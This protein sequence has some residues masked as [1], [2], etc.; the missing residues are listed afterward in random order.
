[1]RLGSLL[2]FEQVPEQMA[3][4]TG[5]RVSRE[6]AR[7]L[8]ETAG[9]ALEAVEAAEVDALEAT[10]A[11]PVS[12]P[13]VQ[14]LS[15]DGAM[16][17]LVGGQWSEVKLLA[18][19]TVQSRPGDGAGVQTSELSYFARLATAEQFGRLATLETYRRGTT[20]AGR[21]AAVLDGAVWLQGLIDLQRPDATRI[22][23]FPHAAEH[24]G[25]AATA[26]WGEDSTRAREWLCGWLHELKHGEPAEVL[27]AVGRLPVS[28]AADPT[29]ATRVVQQTVDYLA[30]R[31]GQIQYAAFRAEG[32]PIGS[33]CVE[34]GHKQVMQARLKGPGMHWAAG[35]VNPLL[36]LRC[37]LCNG[38]WPERWRRLH[39]QWRSA[40]RRPCRRPPR[41]AAKAAAPIAVAASTPVAPTRPTPVPTIVNGRP[42][43]AHPWKRRCPLP[44]SGAPAPAK[45]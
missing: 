8:T 15:A 13:A 16:V 11:A 39:E 7:R 36:S 22:L 37:A 31:W 38:R 32:L 40:T 44:R 24:L 23:D 6:T 41:P 5:S 28:E 27:A 30:S 3:F 21:V 14:Q 10:A 25:S 20:R 42:T 17:P 18:V 12:G 9:A 35:S 33:G 45:S 26:I 1:M 29:Q 19:G 34:S 2:P 43:A 4:F